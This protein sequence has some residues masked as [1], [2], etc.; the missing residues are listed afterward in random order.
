MTFGEKLRKH[1]TSKRFTQS[2]LAKLAGLSINPI[3]NYEKGTTYPQNREIYTK[4]AEILGIDPDYLHNENDTPV[5][6]PGLK[7]GKRAR[8][9]IS[10]ILDD[11]K[12]F[13]ESDRMSDE[14]KDGLMQSLQQL[15]WEA[16][17][18]DRFRSVPR[19]HRK[20]GKPES[21]E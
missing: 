13:F 7:Y 15:Y 11:V 17:K 14:E 10:E 20:S 9:Q 1:R 12:S 16:R 5:D 19:R 21:G 8:R 3:S 2:E 6:L 18:E 4:L